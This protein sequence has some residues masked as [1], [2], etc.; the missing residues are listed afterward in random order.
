MIVLKT[1]KGWT[2]PKEVNG[3]K[4]EGSWRSHQVPLTGVRG[5][6][7]GRLQLEQWLRSYRAEELFDP[8]GR[9]MPEL[10]DLAPKGDRRMGA[11]PHANG[12]VL[13]RDL[14]MPD[15][16]EYAVDV[17]KPGTVTAEATRVLG[18]FLRDVMAANLESA[19]F[20]V[21]GPDETASNRLDALFEVTGRT[22]L[23]E[24]HPDDT[25]ARASSRVTS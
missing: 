22:W 17:G 5:S 16:R 12:G 13:I 8:E 1:P 6:A 20:R 19:N 3:H 9:L 15:F 11:N 10:A 25:C 24:V 21:F 7:A 2:G 4:A 14:H 23:G 18:E